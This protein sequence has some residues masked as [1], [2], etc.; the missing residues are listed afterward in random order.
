MVKSEN[1]IYQKN[2]YQTIDLSDMI[3]PLSDV[4]ASSANPGGDIDGD[5]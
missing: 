5:P 2:Q 3:A 4:D 1:S